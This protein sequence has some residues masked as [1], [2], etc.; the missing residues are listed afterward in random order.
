LH[1][2]H[3]QISQNDNT[4]PPQSHT[5]QTYLNKPYTN[6]TKKDNNQGAF[7]LQTWTL[8]DRQILGELLRATQPPAKTLK[9]DE[10]LLKEGFECVTE[11]NDVKLYRKRK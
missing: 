6:H 11:R 2:T 8:I 3:L 5:Q 7:S 1:D 4:K 9:E 10:E